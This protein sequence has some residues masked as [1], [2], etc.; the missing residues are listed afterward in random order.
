[1]RACFR[2]QS[3]G[4]IKK[5]HDVSVKVHWICTSVKV[6]EGQSANERVQGTHGNTVISC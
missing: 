4:E 2:W 1:M 3:V 5:R 6:R